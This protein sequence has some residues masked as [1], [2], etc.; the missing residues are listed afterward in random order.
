[1]QF[2]ITKKLLVVATLPIVT[3][4]IFSITHF[5]AEYSKLVE[6]K[7]ELIQ[8]EIMN[9]SSTLLHELQIER[10]VSSSYL[11]GGVNKTFFEEMLKK[12]K[13]KTDR[14][15]NKFKLSIH[16]L[17]NSATSNID[18]TIY[19]QNSMEM[20]KKLSQIRKDVLDSNIEIDLMFNYFTSLN[21]KLISILTSLSIEVDSHQIN[22]D[23]VAIKK[24]VQF[25]ELAGQERAL[26][27]SF[28]HLKEIPYQKM[29]MFHNLISLQK[30]RY[31]DLHLLLDKTV[32]LKLTNLKKRIHKSSLI[33]LRKKVLDHEIKKLLL[34]DI[35]KTVGYGGMLY[36]LLRY[37]QS[38]KK[39]FYTNFKLKQKRFNILM[40]Q[41]FDLIDKDTQEYQTALLL[42][43]SFNE[44]KKIDK[45]NILKYYQSLESR[46]IV[47]SNK[48]WFEISTERINQLHKIEKLLLNKISTSIKEDIKKTNELI[49]IQTTL[50]F[51][52]ILLLL[53]AIF[54]LSN[55]IKHSIS[56]LENG[57][58]NFFSFLNFQGEKPDT[59]IIN[60]DDEISSMAQNINL[61]IDII[62]KKLEEDRNFINEATQIV[63][64]MKNGDFSE[65]LYY[66]PHNPHLLELK[67]VFNELIELITAKIDEQANSLE[68]LNRSLED[69]VYEQT[70]VL[71]QQ[72]KEI[73]IARD[74]AIQAELAKD[75]FLANM[76][77][78]I[79][80]P[81]NAILGFVTLIKKRIKD[82]E[83]LNYLDIIDTSS[84][85]LLTIINDIL[86]FSKIQSGKFNIDKQN[87]DPLNEFSNAVLLFASK[88]YEKHLLYT[89]YID[90]N[91]PSSIKIDTV[92]V[93]Q[94]LSNILSNAIKFTP[95]YGEIKVEI[96]S[97]ENSLIIS[98]KD[99]GIGIA[100]ENISKVF[101]AFE[102]ADNSTTR[103][104]GGTGLGL[105]I[106]SKL[107]ALM[108]GDI[109]LHSEVGKGSTFTLTIP[110][111]I[112]DEK[113]QHLI[114]K[115][116]LNRYRFAI[117]TPQ[118]SSNSYFD[119]IKRYLTNFGLTDI[120]ALSEYQKDDYD[121]LFFIPDDAYNE[122]VVDSE[123]PTVAILQSSTVKL[124]QFNHIQ[125]LYTPFTPKMISQSINTSDL[126]TMEVKT[127]QT[128]DVEEENEVQ[129][130]A[131]ILIVEDN[132]TNQMLISLILDDYGIEYTVANN[133]LEA[134][135]I[136]QKQKFDLVLMDENM[137][138]LN[139]IE[140][141]K[142]IKK[143]EEK[144]SLIFTPIIALTASVLESDKKMFMDAG[145]DGFVGKPIDTDELEK[146]LSRF[147]QRV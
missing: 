112:S 83:S 30:N 43:N 15:L 67:S 63:M 2:N 75:E 95:E 29:H 116:R 80:T 55:K 74:E 120:V 107:A 73:T 88:A 91:M 87:I 18:T 123:I 37:K 100:Q 62:D 81:L 103:K 44:I 84:N 146:E 26:V 58:N 35:Y 129:F 68:D 114:D 53:I 14:E 101:S 60:S 85:S 64:L 125:P 13:I 34:N 86:D 51:F 79:R 31:K 143:Y 56:Q 3:L 17:D 25:Q 20:L 128:D 134:V 10:G 7:Q 71:E 1:M 66:D 126:E 21:S 8:L 45:K 89:V 16:K 54:Y 122:E 132:K 127:V 48:D 33:T 124:A 70:I 77:H 61:Q 4:L 92:R 47:F 27:S 133:G 147:L 39:Q 135:D 98:V 106:S 137:P 11:K 97:K 24:M 42:Q 117:L 19:I 118:N 115:E 99:S 9:K 144:S 139:G 76:S 141:M 52:T 110:I 28:S 5:N 121:M 96:I 82:E 6:N 59:I 130:D 145:M 102:Q 12:Q 22:L 40:K 69:R 38:S 113:P 65:H 57:I 50:T 108:D 90:P 131:S 36:E 138:K 72:I 142:R 32:A 140:A 111:E 105:S 119:L 46:E 104:Y 78:E 109:T 41:Y 94:I 93:K 136:F 23:I 49:F